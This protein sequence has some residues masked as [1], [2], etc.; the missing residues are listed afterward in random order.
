MTPAGTAYSRRIASA[1]ERFVILPEARSEAID[2]FRSAKAFTIGSSIGN[3]TLEVIGLNF[4]QVFGQVVECNIPASL[5]TVRLLRY[6]A[7]DV[8]LI[9]WLGGVGKAM[10]PSLAI[11]HQL[12]TKGVDGPSRTD[13][14]SN[15]GYLRAPDGRRIWAVHWMVN[16][17]NNWV[18]GAAE[19]PHPDLD[20]SP[21][22]YVFC[23]AVTKG[24]G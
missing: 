4:S 16:A 7:D 11:I 12:M 5:L 24:T 20:W 21:D 9:E 14:G 13:G 1:H 2:H 8:A 22:T 17:S 23:P 3:H 15:L 6:A 19:V 18:I 10:L